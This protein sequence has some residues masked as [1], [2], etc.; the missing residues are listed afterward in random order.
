MVVTGILA[1]L[2]IS[3]LIDESTSCITKAVMMKLKARE[4][5]KG[6]ENVW[7]R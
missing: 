3:C 4:S 5:L 2:I 7:N 6:V 1:F